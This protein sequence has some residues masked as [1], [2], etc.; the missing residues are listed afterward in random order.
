V[1]VVLLRQ[2]RPEAQDWP[3]RRVLSLL[4]AILWPAAWFVAFSSLPVGAG[5]VGTCIRSL[6][7]L[8]AVARS[9][10]A[11][12]ENASYHFTTYRW[13]S[14]SHRCVFSALR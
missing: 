13:A 12:F 4:D 8:T 6:A 14:R 1:L 9:R 3:G 7:I 5:L 10:R 11:L 2:P